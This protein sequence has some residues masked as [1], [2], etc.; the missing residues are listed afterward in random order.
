MCRFTLPVC[1]LRGFVFAAIGRSWIEYVRESTIVVADCTFCDHHRRMVAPNGFRV[2]AHVVYSLH[3]H[4]IF[5]P[6]CRR[7]VITPRV[8]E[9][10]RVARRQVCAV[11]DA[12]LVE[13]NYEADHVHLL[14]SYPPH[15]SLSVLVHRLKGVSARR[16]R[17]FQYPEVRRYLWGKRFWT[18]AYC[19]VSCGGAPLEVIRRYVQQQARAP[20]LSVGGASPPA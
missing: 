6:K 19:V 1:L 16:V 5:T 14:V 20:S 15:V 2:G 4:I 11:Y 8:F 10:M 18:A 3:A 9:T 12:E 13:S 17:Q 7:R